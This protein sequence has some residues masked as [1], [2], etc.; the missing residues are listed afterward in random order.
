MFSVLTQL[1]QIMSYA[2]FLAKKVQLHLSGTTGAKVCSSETLIFH[3][4]RPYSFH[5]Q[6]PYVFHQFSSSQW[7]VRLL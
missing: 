5:L 1:D 6:K 2:G 7:S 4:Q 3:L